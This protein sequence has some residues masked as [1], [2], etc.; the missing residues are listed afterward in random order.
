MRTVLVSGTA[1]DKLAAS[2]LLVQ[3]SP[4]H[5]LRHLDSLLAL[6]RKHG[7]RESQQALEAL[8]DLFLSNLLPDD[9]RLVPFAARPLNAS[10]VRGDTLV[11]WLFEDELKARYT[12]MLNVLGRHLSDALEHF[13]LAAL[14]TVAALLTDKPEQEAALLTM[15]VNKMGD[16]ENKIASKAGFF[17]SQLAVKHE[18]MKPI[19]VSEVRQ[20]VFRPHLPSVAQYY[21]VVFLNQ[22]QLSRDAPELAAEL[23]DTYFTMFQRCTANEAGLDSRLLSALLTGVNRAFPYA[24]GPALQAEIERR[25]DSIFSIVHRAHN[26]SHGGAFNTAVQALMLLHHVAARRIAVGVPAPAAS[27]PAAEAAAS[28]GESQGSFVDRFYRALYS[29]IAVEI[30]A[31]SSKHALF[32]N[33]LFKAMR[34][35]PDVG[36]TRALVKRLVQ[37]ALYL[38]SSFAAGTIILVAELVAMRPE[39]RG[40]LTG[41]AEGTAD[42]AVSAMKAVDA[43]AI[44]EAGSRVLGSALSASQ[45]CV[46]P[47]V[48]TPP[49]AA[50]VSV[51][52]QP[53]R[54]RHDSDSD[55]STASTDSSS[56]D[57]E[58][59]VEVAMPTANEK[60]RALNVLESVLQSEAV[61]KAGGR[62]VSFD[63][64]E[65]RVPTNATVVA[66]A[67]S[68]SASTSTALEYDPF[69]REPKYCHAERSCLW[70]LTPLAQHFH[71]SVRASFE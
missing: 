48:N 33:L 60:L 22:L 15:L 45:C 66:P 69:K 19:L 42:D 31:T 30:L 11:W 38:P 8:K 71:P 3:E 53:T 36:R 34:G 58:S 26:P 23:L 7:R 24:S 56:D 9:R 65:P 41:Q 2:T 32:L 21:A 57:S 64:A 55:D 51:A 10:G 20:F 35:D 17:L 50:A 13:K 62:V 6:A 29:M 47:P 70:E 12:E 27:A 25:A 14:R 46:E 61:E 59:D 52:V 4:L 28:S 39:T 68:A 40:L 67:T 54:V 5:A 43:G 16:P 63:D 44:V 1:S 49:S 37:V 18:A